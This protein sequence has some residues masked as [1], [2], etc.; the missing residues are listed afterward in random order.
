MDQNASDTCCP[1]T[2]AIL[3]ALY[4]ELA[5]IIDRL[6]LKPV[7]PDYEA[8]H[9]G[10]RIVATVTGV[11]A[12]SAMTTAQRIFDQYK[13]S[14]VIVLGFAGGLDP[15]LSPAT[16]L[17]IA[18]V[19][20][21]QNSLIQLGDADAPPV[22]DDPTTPTVPRRVENVSHR[23]AQHSLLTID[24]IADSV[25]AKRQLFDRYQ[26]AAVDMETYHLAA[27][28]AQR[29]LPLT[30]LRAVTDAAD[31]ALPPEAAH[32]IDPRGR[33]HT[34]TIAWYLATHPWQIGLLL[35]LRKN[36]QLAATRLA[37]HTEALIQSLT[38]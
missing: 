6:G 31:T 21:E 37:D 4:D 17:P 15:Q 9:S 18:W 19:V 11:G 30:V 35:K 29:D 33:A 13:P 14:W 34:A 12:T 26:C 38:P 1:T 24:R 22:D 36:A 23:P 16:V 25:A 10:T 2:V 8:N 7:G 5:P 28:A 20:D 27:L 32:W 3:T